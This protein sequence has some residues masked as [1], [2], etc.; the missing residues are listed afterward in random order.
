M[1][2]G[3][4]TGYIDVAQVTLYAFWIFFAGLV[5][6]LRREDRREG[7]PLENEAA[8]RLKSPDPILIP[9]PKAFHLS[10]GHTMYAPQT[11]IAYDT[12]V[13]SRRRE[14]FPGAPYFRTDTS[15]RAGVG[16]GSWVP[17][18]DEHDRTWDNQYRIVPLRVADAFVVHEDGPNPIGMAVLGA[19]RQVA[20][21]VV[22]LWVD[23]GES[24]VRYYEVELGA[25]GRRV[26]MPVTFCTT[27]RFSR[28]VK[29]EALLAAQ[30]ADIPGIKDPDSVT[31]LEEERIMSYFGAGTLYASPA[32][33]E[34]IL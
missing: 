33:Q 10:S 7:Y 24:F 5:F 32:R 11:N 16:P 14:V 12:N 15:L 3:E 8:G 6:Y 26:L 13:P 28:T 34:P 1:P 18:H 31:L 17:R 2:R 29:T 23:R 20:G 25:G 30:F 4:I 22:D 27:G 19:D 21:T 9:T